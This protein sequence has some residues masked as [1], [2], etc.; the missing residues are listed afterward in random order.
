MSIVSSP[1]MAEV[2]VD[3][4][5]ARMGLCSLTPSA[6]AELVAEVGE[7]GAV[8]VWGRLRAQSSGRA[9]RVDL[10]QVVAGA[11]AA[12]ARFIIPGDA[13][14]PAQLDDLNDAAGAG[15]AGAP[16][17]LWV[18]GRRLDELPAGVAIV[19][20]RAATLHGEHIAAALAAGVVGAGYSLISGLGFGID[21]AAHRGALEADGP[22]IAVIPSG[23][24]RPHPTAARVGPR[25]GPRL[26]PQT[27]ADFSRLRGLLGSAGWLRHGTP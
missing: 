21:A 20:A 18:V 8:D 24:D 17:G 6:D 11:A 1:V 5:A 13:E 22:T 10:A 3:E 2:T 25:P 16:F 27:H 23:L 4:R 14:W 12:G 19:G 15:Q 7:R 26:R 9:A